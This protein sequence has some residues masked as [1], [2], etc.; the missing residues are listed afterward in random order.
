MAITNQRL[1][2]GTVA[3]VAYAPI[4]QTKVVTTMYLCNTGNVSA[5]ANVYAVPAQTNFSADSIATAI[6]VNLPI[7]AGDTYIVDG[8]RIILENGDSILA[9]IAT[10]IPGAVIMTVSSIGT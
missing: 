4:N 5:T 6:Y 3:N 7:A 1:P 9:N 10:G 8:E 2:R